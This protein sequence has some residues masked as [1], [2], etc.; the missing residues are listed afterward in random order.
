MPV[1]FS[2]PAVLPVVDVASSSGALALDC[3]KGNHFRTTLTEATTV[4]APTN[5]TDGQRIIIEV[6]QAAS[7]GPYTL[8]FN[9]V[10]T[11]GAE[12]TAVTI[13]TTASAVNYI[14]AIYNGD[15]SEWHIVG[16]VTGY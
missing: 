12:I 6:V 14:T 2:V 9:A 8:A 1:P 3:N 5:P 15:T 11:Y 4:S 7:G 10:F 13:S 16:A